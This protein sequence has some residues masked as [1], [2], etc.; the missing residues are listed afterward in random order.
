MKAG[1][2]NHKYESTSKSHSASVDI[3]TLAIQ[4]FLKERRHEDLRIPFGLSMFIFGHPLES[5]PVKRAMETGE[6]F[7][8]H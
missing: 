7:E 1:K 8:K 3:V 4:D 2:S 5:P 6:I